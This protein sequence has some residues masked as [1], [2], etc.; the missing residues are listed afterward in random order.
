MIAAGYEQ[1]TTDDDDSM[2]FIDSLLNMKLRETA[3]DQQT[4][5]DLAERCLAKFDD[6]EAPLGCRAVSLYTVLAQIRAGNKSMLVHVPDICQRLK[7]HCLLTQPT[8][9]AGAA[10]FHCQF[11]DAISAILD[12]SPEKLVDE[13][14]GPIVQYLVRLVSCE[15]VEI[16]TRACKFWAEYAGMAAN[17]T[18]RKHWMDLLIPEM[19]TLVRALMDR[20]IYHPAHAEHLQQLCVNSARETSASSDV[21][22]FTNLRNL[23]V[24]AFEHV[25]RAYPAELVCS[26]F[27]P[28]LEKRIQFDSWSEKEAVI[29]A[30]AAYTQGAGIPDAMRDSYALVVPRVLDC[31]F[32][33][34]PLLRSVACLTMPKLVGRR[35]RGVKEPWSRVLICTAK[36]TR[37]SSAEVRRTAIRA[38][39]S[40][41]AYGTPS[42]GDGKSSEVGGHTA[43]LVGALDRAAQYEMDPETRCAYFDCVSH[44][45]GRAGDALTADDMNCLMPRLIDAWKSQP[46]N[47]T[48][49]ADNTDGSSLDPDLGIVPFSVSLGTIA[50]YGKSRYAPF[51]EC[52][53]EKACTDIGGFYALC[54]LA[55]LTDRAIYIYYMISSTE[56]KSLV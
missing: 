12:L 54:I 8:V 9:G 47:R 32:D 45:V 18:V 33:P 31:Y 19:S 36:A 29:L 50:S 26:T 27:R 53:F 17:V 51:A 46:W 25:A 28:L 43:R 44:L 52:I 13:S 40:L 38:L 2:K 5:D 4:T 11:F 6:L 7:T 14:L 3:L 21:E 48:L 20:M 30:L 42:G 1:V 41:L 22:S 56:C 16:A 35:L 10:D 34:H 39:S 49:D 55:C 23:A 15:H 24:V 37:D